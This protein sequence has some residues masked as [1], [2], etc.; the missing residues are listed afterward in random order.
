M[1]KV[2]NR[3]MDRKC[4]VCGAPIGWVCKSLKNNVVLKRPHKER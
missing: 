4:K 2:K 1:P 3:K